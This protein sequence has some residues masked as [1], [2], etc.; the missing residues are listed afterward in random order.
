MKFSVCTGA[1]WWFQDSQTTS[2]LSDI[3][4]VDDRTGWIV[5]QNGT[6][7]KTTTGGRLD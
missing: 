4:S 5:G 3:M 2:H 6:I 1:S 7:L